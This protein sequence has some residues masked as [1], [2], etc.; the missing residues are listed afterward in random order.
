MHMEPIVEDFL[1]PSDQYLSLSLYHAL[2]PQETKSP[3]IDILFG[4]TD[5]DAINNG[6]WYTLFTKTI[7]HTVIMRNNNYYF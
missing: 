5:L 2:A 7:L 1:S 3:Q 4:T 6:G